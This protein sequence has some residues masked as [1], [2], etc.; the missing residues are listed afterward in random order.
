M[1]R[2]FPV[3]PPRCRRPWPWSAR[4]RH[5]QMACLPHRCRSRNGLDGQKATELPGIANPALA[6]SAFPASLPSFLGSSAVLRSPSS[7]TVPSPARHSCPGVGGGGVVVVPSSPCALL[8]ATRLPVRG[9]HRERMRSRGTRGDGPQG[10]ARR[11]GAVHVLGIVDPCVAPTARRQG[12]GAALLQA[13][14]ERANGQ[15]FAL[16]MA[17]GPRPCRG[18]GHGLIH[19][20]DVMFPAV[21]GSRRH[22][23]VRR[24]LSETFTVRRLAGDAWPDGPIDLPG[25]LS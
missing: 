24:D 16:A 3:K 21:D 7:Q 4:K 15:S 11:R 1:T 17:D 12:I 5:Q 2:A 23:V 8:L 6:A 9:P 20:A 18:A 25:R 19:A 22:S 13:A 14:E 10:G